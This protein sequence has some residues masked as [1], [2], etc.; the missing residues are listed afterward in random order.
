MSR[1][2]EDAVRLTATAYEADVSA[3][4]E[5]NADRTVI[6]PMLDRLVGELDRGDLVTDLG[7]GPGWETAE[8]QRRGFRVIGVDISSAMLS[9]ASRAH[10]AASFT[11]GDVR[12]LPLAT[13]RFSGAW[14]CASFL[15]LPK[16]QLPLALAEVLR[17]LVPGGVFECSVQSGEREVVEQ[18]TQAFAQPR[19]YAHYQPEEW[20]SALEVAGLAVE[21]LDHTL[22]APEH[23]NTGASGWITALA[24]K[25]R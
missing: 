25:P 24:R 15:H 14:A 22:A 7:C 3:F 10:A 4:I 12:Q 20:R 16:P 11:R 13:G 21:H 17:I 6:A 2:D 18:R 19:F 8:L 23:L 9:S 1:G 5:L